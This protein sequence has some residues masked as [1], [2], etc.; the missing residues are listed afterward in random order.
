LTCP[1]TEFENNF[2]R[3]AAATNQD[4][5]DQCFNQA[6]RENALDMNLFHHQ[7]DVRGDTA[8]PPATTMRDNRS[9]NLVAPQRT[10]QH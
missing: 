8:L 9:E 6:S 4:G 2:N 10:P 5:V 3:P 7:R 1:R